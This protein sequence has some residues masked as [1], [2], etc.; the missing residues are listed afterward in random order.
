MELWFTMENYGT[1]EK[2]YGT[3]YYGQNYGT[4]LRTIE[5]R[6]T[7]KKKHGRLPNTKKLWFIMEQTME[8]YQNN[9]KL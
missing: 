4:T 3:W 7:E 8:I 9:S 1:M 5:L 6:F 2:N